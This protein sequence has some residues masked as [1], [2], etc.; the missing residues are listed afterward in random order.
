MEK[1]LPLND[2][3]HVVIES[4]HGKLTIRTRPER[5][6]M[7]RGKQFT[8]NIDEKT[9]HCMIRSDQDLNLW[10][11]KQTELTIEKAYGSVLV[12]G[13]SGG[14]Y[15]RQAHGQVH[16]KN[17][18]ATAIARIHGRLTGSNLNGR[19]QVEK[20]LG[21]IQLKNVM[22][23]QCKIVD[24][25]LSAHYVSGEVSIDKC[26]GDIFLK[27]VSDG[28]TIQQSKRDVN[29]QNI[30]GIINVYDAAG[31]VR[32]KERLPMGKHIINADSD[33]VIR[34]PIAAPVLIDAHAPTITNRLPLEN[35]TEEEGLLNGRI[36]DGNTRLNL[37]AQ[38]NVILKPLHNSTWTEDNASGEDFT[39]DL[40]FNIEMEHLGRHMAG[41]GEQIAAEVSDKMSKLTTQLEGQFKALRKKEEAVRRAKQ[42][43]EK[44]MQ[45]PV[46]RPTPPKAPQ[47]PTPPPPPTA[48]KPPSEM[49]HLK[50]LEILQQGKISVDEAHTL[51]QAIC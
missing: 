35:V 34:W 50:I 51:L 22:G 25:D 46:K 5:R 40:D 10:L 21:D 8:A 32:L 33:I 28:V 31:D 19:L 29:L 44:Y 48:P 6:L 18:G 13:I 49:A 39:V 15:L 11:P 41:L 3:T 42:R 37:K 4:C 45:T 38:S 26:M 47:P 12:K 1:E 30:G 20:A 27:T 17:V 7:A 9:G 23:I 24:G 14:V 2:P 43:A 16:L 36:G